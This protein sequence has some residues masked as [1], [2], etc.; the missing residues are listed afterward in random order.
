MDRALVGHEVEIRDGVITGTD[1]G[2]L[3]VVSYDPGFYNT[4]ACRSSITHIDAA[5]GLL[6]YRGYPIEELAQTRSFTEV[7]YLLVHGVLP[8]QAERDQYAATLHDHDSIPERSRLVID[9]LPPDTHPMAALQIAIATLTPL[10]SERQ[11]GLLDQGIRLIAVIPSLVAYI[12]R[13]KGSSSSSAD[14]VTR[15]LERC[16]GQ[17]VDAGLV[18]ALDVVFTLHADH[19]QNCSTNVLRAVLSARS[20]LYAAASAGVGALSGPLHGGANEA[21][22]NMLEEIETENHIPAFM[23][24]V[25]SKKRKI[26]GFGHPVYKN[27]DPRAAV[28]KSIVRDALTAAHTDDHLLTLALALE[29]AALDDP[30]FVDRHLYPN[31]DFYSGLVYRALGFRKDEFTCLFAAARASGWVAHAVEQSND[32]DVKIYRPRQ[33]FDGPPRRSLR[34][35]R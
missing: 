17:T 35:A 30:Y 23:A 22:M 21:V 31:V 1:L 28:L 24:S 19:E 8:N 5:A 16:A 3:G 15:L 20:G 10:A 29:H 9:S 11:A 18:R 27:Y 6:E 7:S 4:A 13:R 33:L 25:I 32:P 2:R 14:L 34:A 26:F 12:H